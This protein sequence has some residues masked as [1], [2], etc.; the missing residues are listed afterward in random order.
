M[1]IVYISIALVVAYLLGAVPTAVW[2]GKRFYNKDVRQFGSGNA[3]AT[4]TFRVLGKRAGIA[5]LFFDVLKGWS[6]TSLANCLLNTG[7]ISS[8]ELLYFQLL[9]GITAVVGHIFPIYVGFKGGKG[10]ATLL[11]VVLAIYLQVAL[12]SIGIF[13]IVFLVWHYVSLGS[14]LAALSYP[15]LMFIPEF[16]PENPVL[17]IVG[18][19][20][21]ILVIW[22]HRENIQRLRM[23]SESKIYLFKRK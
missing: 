23:G 7:I 10:V 22:T 18:F 1:D 2:V 16:R 17:N 6:A 3:G 11:G 12:L 20:L 13:L 19:V 9:Y 8:S 5:V 14:M 15:L 21:C 4:N